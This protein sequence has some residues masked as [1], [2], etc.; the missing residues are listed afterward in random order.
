M[1]SKTGLE[2]VPFGAHLALVTGL[3]VMDGYVLVKVLVPFEFLVALFVRIGKLV[4]MYK[5][6]IPHLDAGS[7]PSATSFAHKG[8]LSRV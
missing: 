3:S 7:E 8:H 6:V 4:F 5:G 2:V 1:L